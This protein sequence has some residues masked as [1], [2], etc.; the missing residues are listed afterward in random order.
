ML[1][2]SLLD[3][4]K[5]KKPK[6]RRRGFLN[7]RFVS[8]RGVEKYTF[9]FVSTL[10]DFEKSLWKTNC[11]IFDNEHSALFSFS[12]SQ[13]TNVFKNSLLCALG[14]FSLE[15][16]RNT[17]G[18]KRI[19]FVIS[20]FKTRAHACSSK[21]TWILLVVV[22]AYATNMIITVSVVKII[23]NFRHLVTRL[24]GTVVWKQV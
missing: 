8:C 23:L 20:V 18:C 7:A 5:R 12:T 24:Q 1:K 13:F 6:C 21:N 11:V 17:F 16:R 14:R 2:N 3:K 19:Q 15:Q 10:N 22:S 9:V 4:Q